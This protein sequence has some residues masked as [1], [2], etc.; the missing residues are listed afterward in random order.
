MQ[1]AIYFTPYSDI[2]QTSK[3]LFVHGAHRRDSPK[4]DALAKRPIQPPYPPPNYSLYSS[5]KLS[6]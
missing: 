2:L 3:F 6:R 5:Y 4:R 1:A